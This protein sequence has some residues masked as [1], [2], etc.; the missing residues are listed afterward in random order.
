MDRGAWRGTAHGVIQ[1]DT[2][3]AT[4]HSTGVN[5]AGQRWYSR[6]GSLFLVFSRVWNI[7]ELKQVQI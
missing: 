4:E 3:E 7:P 1:S 2:T 5:Q 6:A